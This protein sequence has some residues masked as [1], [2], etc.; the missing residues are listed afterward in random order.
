MR[1]NEVLGSFEIILDRFVP[2]ELI[3]ASLY[4]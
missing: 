1:K 3:Y 4:Y 2:K